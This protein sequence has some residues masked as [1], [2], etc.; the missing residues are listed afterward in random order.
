MRVVVD[1]SVFIAAVGSPD[2]ASREVLRRCLEGE[3][4]PVMGQALLSEYE[5][6]LGREAPFV[7]SPVSEVER[8]QLWM[9]LTSVCHWIRVY[10][11]WRPNLPDEGDNH[12]IEL[13]VAGGAKTIVTFNLRDFQR[14]ELYFPDIAVLTPSQLVAG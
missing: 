12:L 9:A 3:Y 8:R 10:Y 7:R 13:A 11:L 4:E 14:T 1:T 6:V 5:A 2:G